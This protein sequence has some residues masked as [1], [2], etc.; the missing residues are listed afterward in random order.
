MIDQIFVLQSADMLEDI[1]AYFLLLK[2]SS[3]HNF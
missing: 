1:E 3:I 2:N